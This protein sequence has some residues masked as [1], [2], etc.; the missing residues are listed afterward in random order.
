MRSRG[1]PSASRTFADDIDVLF[2]GLMIGPDHDLAEQ[3]HGDEL[4]ADDDEE[5]GEE[6]ERTVADARP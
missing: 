6:E 4:E 1:S 3:P 5:D 2:D